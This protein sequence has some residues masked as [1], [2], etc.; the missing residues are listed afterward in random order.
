[1][2]RARR[3]EFGNR[4]GHTTTGN[5]NVNVHGG[6]GGGGVVAVEVDEYGNPI[7][8]NVPGAAGGHP[9]PVPTSQ[10]EHHAA[11]GL[12]RSGS[13]SSSSSEEDDGMGGRRKKKGLKEKLPGGAG[14]AGTAATTTTTV[15]G[16]TV[17]TRPRR[18]G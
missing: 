18:R 8:G 9:Q 15:T 17:P 6:G 5:P 3:D 12:H 1:M 7:A 13:G 2:E 4:V 14:H 16:A 11:T 10:T